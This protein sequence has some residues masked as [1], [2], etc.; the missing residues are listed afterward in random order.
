MKEVTL[1]TCHRCAIKK[2]DPS[3]AIIFI[4]YTANYKGIIC[5]TSVMIHAYHMLFLE[6]GQGENSNS[7]SLSSSKIKEK[8]RIKQ[9]YKHKPMQSIAAMNNSV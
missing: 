2:N 9:I 3:V 8:K 4:T 1:K 7:F 5:V 6:Y